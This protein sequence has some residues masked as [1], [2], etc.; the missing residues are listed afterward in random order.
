MVE[1]LAKDSTTVADMFRLRAER[2]PNRESYRFKDEGTW[3]QRT[4][5]DL[6]QES[7]SLAVALHDLGVGRGDA[8]AILA[9]CCPN[10]CLCDMGTVLVGAMSVGLYPTLLV[11]QMQFI[12]DDSRCKL[13]F[14]QGQEQYDKVKPLLEAV[15]GL[16]WLVTWDVAEVEGEGVHRLED[17]LDRGRELLRDQPELP[18][19]FVVEPDDTA[20]V[21]Y[22]SGT[23]G[24]PK[25]VPL[26][27]RNIIAGLSAADGLVDDEITEDDITMSFLPMAHVAEHV[28]GFY[29]RINIG[30]KTAFA[31]N[32]ET[33]LDELLEVRPTYFGAVPRIFEKMYGRIHE[34][35]GKANPRRQAIFHWAKD[36]A[37]RNGRAQTGGAPLSA[38]DRVMLK[39]ADRL[40]YRRI[41]AVFGGR[42]KGFV[43]G[44]APINI[45]ILEFFTGLGM[46]IIE[47]Y[48]LS[49]ST[50]ISFA[51][52]LSDI[53]L[54]T[55]GRAIPGVEFK[56]ADDGEIL[57]RG[58]T[59]FSGYL[60]LPDESKESFDDEGYLKTG[61]IG[62]VDDEGY[63]RITDRKK[64]LIKTAG[65]KYVV[66]ARI[67]SL[68]KDEPLISQVYVHGDRK[69]YVVGLV[70]LDERETG[71]VAELLGVTE[72]DL[73]THPEVIRRIEVAIER[74]NT[75]LAR[76]EQLKKHS[77]LPTDFSIEDGTLTPTM[78]IKRKVVAERYSERLEEL[79][80]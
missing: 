36:L 49:E 52:T 31:T 62:V 78:K 79:Y 61:D 2:T 6:S 34:E 50:A 48:G 76:F 58:P 67:E 40:I 39:V 75:R 44:S 35:V 11:D 25:G 73:P 80:N 24:R 30:L 70:T 8:V 28:P 32:Y 55:V 42:V 16:Q 17:L 57:L 59:I 19:S 41:R 66:P 13:L 10:W 7:D 46:R 68:V 23:T 37:R 53:R 56:L 60:N 12:V 72:S 3:T 22:T 33:L 20:L 47:V 14:V 54:G 65:G 51:N 63:L 43:T 5:A 64:N 45:E 21:V 9:E 74:G 38:V 18:G 26:T 71:R 77:I 29:G 1:M 15:D 27:H 4:W 69:P